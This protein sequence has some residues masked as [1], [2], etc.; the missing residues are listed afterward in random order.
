MLNA[1]LTKLVHV[2][3]TND[4]SGAYCKVQSSVECISV[5]I[6]FLTAGR[7]EAAVP[8]EEVN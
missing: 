2:M 3:L 7:D 4:R 1:G 5:Q 6:V 8:T